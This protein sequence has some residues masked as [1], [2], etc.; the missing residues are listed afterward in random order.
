MPCEC[1]M[2]TSFI[3]CRKYLVA[4]RE[5]R[6]AVA[7]PS[8]APKLALFFLLRPLWFA[9]SFAFGCCF[10]T[11]NLL[12][13]L[14][15]VL[16]FEAEHIPT[17]SKSVLVCGQMKKA[18]NMEAINIFFHYSLFCETTSTFPFC[19]EKTCSFLSPQHMPFQQ[20]RHTWHCLALAFSL[21]MLSLKEVTWNNWLKINKT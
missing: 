18:F 7:P 9:P 4:W 17:L 20:C 3:Q 16:D 5:S 19:H 1:H 2:L 21:F 8:K 11:Q 13:V 10:M 15:K 12:E 14:R 6:S